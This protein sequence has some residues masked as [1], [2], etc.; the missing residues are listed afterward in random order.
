MPMTATPAKISRN[1]MERTGEKQRKEV[2]PRRRRAKSLSSLSYPHCFHRLPVLSISQGGSEIREEENDERKPSRACGAQY[3]FP[4]YL[5]LTVLTGSLF[6]QFQLRAPRA[7]RIAM[8]AAVEPSA[9]VTNAARH[10]GGL[11]A[12][13][14]ASSANPTATGPTNAAI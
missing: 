10:P 3:L 5:I 8:A 14:K 2:T 11:P 13:P 1:K 7:A 12:P 6:Y 9:I 4:H